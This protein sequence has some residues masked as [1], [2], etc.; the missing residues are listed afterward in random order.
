M[1]TVRRVVRGLLGLA[2]L[3]GAALSVAGAAGGWVLRA[4]ATDRTDRAFGRLT[5]A[6][7]AASSDLSR[8]LGQLE[9]TREELRALRERGSNGRELDAGE[10]PGRLRRRQ[11]ADAAAVDLERLRRI[12][13]RSAEAALV[14]EGFMDALAELRGDD[15]PG[16][17]AGPLRD[18]ADRLSDAA[19]TARLL[20]AYLAPAGSGPPEPGDGDPSGRLDEMLAGAAR[21]AGEGVERLGAA[22]DRAAA[23]RSSLIAAYTAAAAAWT[24]L[25]AWVGAGQVSLLVLAAGRSRARRGPSA[26]A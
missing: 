13:T 16:G 9:R 18:A 14:A 17:D 11:A 24:A 8:A 2:G 26:V 12:V 5:V 3:A 22:R 25:L 19:D 6:L 4:G 21:V 20:S 1:R 10:E 15:R 7:D 23:A